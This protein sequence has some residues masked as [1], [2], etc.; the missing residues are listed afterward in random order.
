VTKG[1]A[2]DDEDMKKAL[3]IP[4]LLVGLLVATVGVYT[5]NRALDGREMVRS[6]LL[7]QNVT[8]PAQASIPNARVDDAAT[9]QSMS[10][11]IDEALEGPTGGRNYNEIGRYLTADGKDTNDAAAAALAADG[12]PM[13][14]P[15]R[16][17]AFEAS[18]GQTSL[19]LSVA[20][21]NMVDMALGLGALMLVL[22]ATMMG[23]GIAMIGVPVPAFAR[24]RRTADAAVNDISLSSI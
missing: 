11:F 23:G 19:G 16:E 1:T 14:N 4:M 21:F 15:L 20:A 3:G 2:P 9:A 24:R 7:E 13:E 5:I 22:A 8:T 6:A 17:I 12:M 10:D 18:T